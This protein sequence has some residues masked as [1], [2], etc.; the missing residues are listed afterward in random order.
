[1][2]EMIDRL[3]KRLPSA[4]DE[5]L[6]ALYF[7]INKYQIEPKLKNLDSSGFLFIDDLGQT[8][9]C[10][11][12]DWRGKSL[13]LKE[14]PKADIVV[15][16]VQGGLFCGWVETSKLE[17]LDDRFVVSNLSLTP[18]P[19]SYAFLP[20]CAHMTQHGGFSENG[21]PWVCF[22]CEQELVFT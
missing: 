14:D 5:H 11:V 12:A 3:K 8:V 21:G 22:N 17:N 19:D 7:L 9:R 6:N 10:L 4:S 15:I 1:M 16:Y 2:Q 18:L 13:Y 20:A